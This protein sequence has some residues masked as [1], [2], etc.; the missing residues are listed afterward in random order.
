MVKI[1]LK[2][3]GLITLAFS[4]CFQSGGNLCGEGV[5]EFYLCSPSSNAK[6]VRR[7]ENSCSNFIYIKGSLKGE[8]VT[9]YKREELNHLIKELNAKLVFTETG[10]DF[11]CEYYYTD[12]LDGY[13]FL[14]NKKINLHVSYQENLFLVGTPIIFGSYWKNFYQACINEIFSGNNHNHK[15]K[16]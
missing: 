3:L 16:P 4:L 8:K 7:E 15:G 14:K 12:K 10:D 2:L 13:I 9:F 5:H 11:L 6:I 1:I